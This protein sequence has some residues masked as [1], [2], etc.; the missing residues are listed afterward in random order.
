MDKQYFVLLNII[1]DVNKFCI[2]YIYLYHDEKDINI[3]LNTI[4]VLIL[5]ILI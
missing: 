2:N 5:F 1:T 3:S 4:F